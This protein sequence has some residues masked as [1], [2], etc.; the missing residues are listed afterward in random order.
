MGQGRRSRQK[1]PQLHKLFQQVQARGTGN[2]H[3]LFRLAAS[4]G[5]VFLHE[6]EERPFLEEFGETSF[7]HLR[8]AALGSAPGAS[9]M[10]PPAAG[11]AG[12]A[13]PGARGYLRGE[14]PVPAAESRLPSAAGAGGREVRALRASPR[15]LL[16]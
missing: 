9:A 11:R 8:C 14:A 5:L 2:P 12:S 13:S 3:L 6:A 15:E 1:E 7:A 16:P 4:Q 10:G